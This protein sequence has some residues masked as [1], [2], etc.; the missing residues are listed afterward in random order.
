MT[1]QVQSGT[2]TTE[3]HATGQDYKAKATDGR[4]AF[5][6]LLAPVQRRIYVG[7]GIAALSGI[8][9]IW[10]YIAL[11]RLGELLLPVTQGTSIN[12]DAVLAQVNELVMAFALQLFLYFVALAVTH[13]ADVKLRGHLQ[14][15]ILNHLGR[16]PLS[17]F[18][19]HASG[20]VRKV[21]QG[22]TQTLHTLVAHQPG[23]MM[24]AIVTPLS[25]MVYAFI[26]NPWLGLKA[27]NLW[28]VLRSSNPL[29]R[30]VKRIRLLPSRRKTL[31]IST[32][33]GADPC[34][35]G[36]RSHWQ[37]FRHPW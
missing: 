5:K 4:K 8:A 9:A 33:L 6:E 25:L 12:K 20:R 13:F 3:E 7:Q 22:D 24:A 11:T 16:A 32:G 10:P 26:L 2:S 15:R 30:P 36:L 29:G 21:L 19:N 28:M 17:W 18:S 27:W 37:L 34:S 1:T 14:Q 31:Q 23:E 35:R